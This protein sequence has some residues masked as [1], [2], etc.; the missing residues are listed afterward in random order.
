[1]EFGAGVVF[2]GLSLEPVDLGSVPLRDGDES[3]DTGG[4]EYGAAVS[5]L[6]TVDGRCP[7]TARGDSSS[8]QSR[9]GDVVDASALRAVP[10][11][12][13]LSAGEDTDWIR[14]PITPRAGSPVRP[15]GL[16]G[17][18]VQRRQ[19]AAGRHEGVLHDPSRLPAWPRDS[20]PVPDRHA[21]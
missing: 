13:T 19:V 20:R 8:N 2:A 9:Y 14:P 7:F 21:A 11:P 10:K 17:L 16:P 1:M 4:K 5:D 6:V 12:G 3:D 18:L 15:A